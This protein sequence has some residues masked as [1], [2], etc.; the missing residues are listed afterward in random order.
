MIK[1]GNTA[2]MAKKTV[3]DLDVNG[4]KVIVRADL[5]VPHKGS[6]ITNDN[7]V[8]AAIP[9][10]KYLTDNGAKVILMSHLG[11]VK[12]D[13]DKAKNDLGIVAPRLQELLPDVTVKFCPVTR[14][15]ELE[16]MVDALKPGEILL[17]QN[18]R[19]EK[20]ESK[21]DP[22][23]GKY[24]AGLADMF[25][26][27][28]F[29]SVHRA[30]AS[31][32]GIPSNLPDNA[33]GFLVEK[34]VDM[35]GKAV[36]DPV[37]PFVA[38]LGGAKVSDKIAVIENMLDKADKVIVGGGMAYTFEKALGH[39]VGNSLL[40]EDKIDLAKQILK[41]GEGKLVLPVDTVIA[42]AFSNDANTQIVGEDIP[43]GWMGLDIGPKS[44]E[45]FKKT[46]E[47]AKTVV[48]NGPMGVFEMPKFA[49]GTLKVCE[50]ISELPGATTVIGGG[51][52]AAA[53]IQLGF[54]DKFSHIS[55][56]GGASL[57]YMEGKTL[58]GIA[59]IAEKD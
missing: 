12:T 21:N 30:H 41:K 15:E 59:I 52:S 19:Y 14:G 42:D 4:K 47:G 6:E 58:P 45:L 54:E 27:D 39:N 9:T 34:E 23:L 2:S 33:L 13:E 10:L 46:L 55:T 24:W 43:D 1:G 53:A 40:E 17:M 35:L 25:V 32:V 26:E 5:N 48:W 50:A 56:G 49:N 16:A 31:T 18:T 57:E 51:D 11:K 20:G 29:G 8:K 36:D 28:A 37:H 22:E 44:I 7:R 38:I 3:K